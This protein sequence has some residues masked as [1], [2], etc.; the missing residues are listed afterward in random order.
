MATKG[1]SGKLAKTTFETKPDNNLAVVD[2]YESGG[3]GIENSFQEAYHKA[4]AAFDDFASLGK[5]ALGSSNSLIDSLNKQVSNINGI[6]NGIKSGNLNSLFNLTGGTSTGLKQLSDLVRGGVNTVNGITRGVNNLTNLG[7]NLKG[8]LNTKGF[9]N[10]LA[11]NIPL[12]RQIQDLIRDT[13][14]IKQAGDSLESSMGRASNMLGGDRSSMNTVV[15]GMRKPATQIENPGRFDKQVTTQDTANMI[16]RFAD[17]SPDIGSALAGLPQATKEALT[18]GFSD[19]SLNKGLIVT[20]KNKVTRIGPEVSPDVV[21]PINQ[22]VD[23]FTGRSPTQSQT[24]DPGAIAGL[25]SGV[26]NLAAKSGIKDTFTTITKSI[27]NKEIISQAA[28]PL[29]IR[30]I[31]E[32]DMD[33]VI[34]LSKSKA[35]GDLK[36]FAPNMVES[37]CYNT[38]RPEGMSQQQFAPYYQE[39]KS[40]FTAIDPNWSTYAS[41]S[42]NKLINGAVICSNAFV[43]DIIEAMLNELN[44][45]K[46]TPK[47]RQDVQSVILSPEQL[48]NTDVEPPVDTFAAELEKEVDAL[49][50]DSFKEAFENGDTIITPP[51][52]PKPGEEGEGTDPTTPEVPDPEPVPMTFHDEPFL[53]LAS[54]FVDNSVQS[55]IEKHFPELNQRFLA[56]GTY[57]R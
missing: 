15:N 17:I 1:A 36:S 12:G 54:V 3:G 19:E 46:L 9:L 10:R 22:I 40:A 20:D 39:V 26:T 11:N 33:T 28:K 42:G 31:E 41:G 18:R 44:N 56:M 43:C 14:R 13:G 50:K 53:L 23:S 25:I 4:N 35:S 45:P 29:A 5:S 47:N 49:N 37:I 57:E 8:G 21:K 2:V 16:Q 55:E 52:D 34:D 27:T 48:T 30:A 7:N 51:E 24:Q 6:L 32:G 38:L